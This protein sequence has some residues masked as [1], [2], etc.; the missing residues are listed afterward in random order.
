M[1]EIP[2]ALPVTNATALLMFTSTVM[3]HDSLP[4]HRTGGRN[5]A[6]LSHVP[7]SGTGR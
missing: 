7:A 3:D 4:V 2:R 5:F 6:L 1:A